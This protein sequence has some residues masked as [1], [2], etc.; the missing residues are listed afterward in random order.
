MSGSPHHATVDVILLL[1]QTPNFR[2]ESNDLNVGANNVLTFV[3]NGRPGF[4]IDYRL[5]DPPYG[6]LFPNNSI[7]NNLDEALYSA[8]GSDGCPNSQGQWEQFTA[9]N[10]KNAGNTLVVRNLN[11]C[12]A[13][14]GYTLRVTN[15]NGASYVEL[16]PGGVNQ[17]GNQS[18]ITV[19]PLAAGIVGAVAGS[20]LTLGVQAFLK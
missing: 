8:V 18:L 17:N 15:D 4:W 13:V 6:Y 1:G 20:A 11:D 9:K 10:V 16:D 5:K 7:P 14:F 2:F 12:A 19:S 3:N